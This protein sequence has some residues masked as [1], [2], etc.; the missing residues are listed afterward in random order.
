MAWSSDTAL[1]DSGADA[2]RASN[3]FSA[4]TDVVGKLVMFD[5]DMFIIDFRKTET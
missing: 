4:R 2:S 1:V 5:G 3:S